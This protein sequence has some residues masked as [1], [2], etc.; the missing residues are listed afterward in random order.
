[1]CIRDRPIA[2]GA[3]VAVMVSYEFNPDAATSISDFVNVA[4]ISDF[5]SLDGRSASSGAIADLD[6]TPDTDPDNDNGG[7]DEE[8]S[9]DRAGEIS[10]VD[11]T[12]F[13]E[14]GDEDDADPALV[15]Y[16]DFALI[17]TT[18]EEG[19]FFPGQPVQYDIT[20]INQ[21]N[22]SASEVTVYDYKPEGLD[23]IHDPVLNNGWTLD[24]DIVSYTYIG[25]L[26]P[27]ASVQVQIYMAPNGEDF[28]NVGLTNVAEIGEVFNLAGSSIGQFD[29]D[30]T[31]D[32]SPNNDEGG[33]S[34]GD[35]D[36]TT[37]GE[38]GDEDDADPAEICLITI[39]CPE[40]LELTESCA[41]APFETAEEAGL[42]LSGNSCA[43]IEFELTVDDVLEP[44]ECTNGEYHSTRTLTR[45]YLSL[46]HISEPTRP[47]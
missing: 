4:E 24:G 1:M 14:N 8:G 46:I 2:S 40:D 21:G 27:G 16:V 44:V 25:N 12:I 36:D 7:S 33:E 37:D 31:P 43:D 42:L 13:N 38:N 26:E 10:G 19:P 45:S 35:T 29:I 39:D 32:D 5:E 20:I 34:G 3:S 18:A 47:Y 15:P 6:S 11:N 23:Y 22:V 17:K 30:S 9:F 41:V 28:S